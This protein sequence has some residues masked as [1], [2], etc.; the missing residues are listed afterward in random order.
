[1][2]KVLLL[3][4]LLVPGLAPADQAEAERRLAAAL[5]NLDNLTADFKQTLRNEDKQVVQQSSGTLALQ[6]PGK[7]AWIYTDP[8]EQQIVADGRELWVYDVELDQVTVK[9]IDES[10]SSA[11]I[12]LLMKETD[13][14]AQFRISEVGQRKFLYWVELEPQAPDLEFTHIYI[15][16][17]DG[18][19]RAM[20]MLGRFGQSTQIVFENLR[21]GVVHDPKTFRFEPPPGVDV[22]GVG[23]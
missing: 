5:K 1:M 2:K 8:F 18:T 7:F 11:P 6:R 13:V 15:G 23:G 20:E 17:E 3:L 21:V 16:L 19:V 12:M 4:I 9:P 10:I 14:S 22:Y